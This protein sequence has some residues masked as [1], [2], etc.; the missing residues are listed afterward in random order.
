MNWYPAASSAP[1]MDQLCWELCGLRELQWGRPVVRVCLGESV[2]ST[3][4]RRDLQLKGEVEEFEALVPW[5]VMCWAH[6]P[7]PEVSKPMGCRTVSTR[8]YYQQM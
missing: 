6:S 8:R 3:G 5:V 7:A 2:S 1:S 4:K